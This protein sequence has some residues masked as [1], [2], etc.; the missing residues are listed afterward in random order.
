MLRSEQDEL[1][2]AQQ[3]V[4]LALD[5]P[6][7][8]VSMDPVRA[9]ES[10]LDG[11]VFLDT[12]LEECI[13]RG[14][15][16]KIDPSTGT[17]YHTEDNMPEDPK[18]KERLQ[19]H[20]DERGEETMIR[21]SSV[22]FDKTATAIKTWSSQFG[23]YAPEADECSIKNNIEVCSEHW[24]NQQLVEEQVMEQMGKLVDFKQHLY[25]LQRESMR[26]KVL[27]E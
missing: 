7:E 26:E 19:D 21:D 23:Q 2:E 22:K 16:R 17:I 18:V 14:K 20:K 8:S 5:A 9:I 6:C 3:K 25:N 24:N 11:V 12:P 4:I 15:G 27:V 13:R 1:C 10:G